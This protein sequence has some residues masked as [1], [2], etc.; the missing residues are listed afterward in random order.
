MDQDEP[1]MNPCACGCGTLVRGTWKRGHSRRGYAGFQPIP[2]PDAP[3][4][5]F[6]DLGLIEPT[7]SPET[8]RAK[9]EARA[10]SPYRTASELDG[11]GDDPGDDLDDDGQG[12]EPGDEPRPV[13]PGPAHTRR[14]WRRRK[15]KGPKPRSY[16][17]RAPRLTATVRADVDA[18][19]SFALEIPG[20]LWQARDPVCG[21]AFVEQRPEISAALTEI[22]CNSPD[23]LAWFTGAGGGYLLYLNLLAT[24]WPVATLWLAH[25]IYHSIGYEPEQPG[26]TYGQY[27][28]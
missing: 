8:V 13:S 4:S 24:C 1:Q 28:A 7:D 19:I 11:Q 9:L 17:A 26:V 3:D 23:L 20:R 15:P 12:D 5:A 10:A 14:E 16:Q 2:P 27:A 6:E 21:A 25:H 22:V 18:K